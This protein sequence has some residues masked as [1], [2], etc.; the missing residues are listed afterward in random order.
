MLRTRRARPRD[1]RTAW[2]EC[3]DVDHRRARRQPHRAG[4][5]RHLHRDRDERYRR[6]A[7]SPPEPCC[8]STVV[9]CSASARS[10]ATP[11]H[12][13]TT[14]LVNPGKHDITAV[15]AGDAIYN[16]STSSVL[17][18]TVSGGAATTT[19]VVSSQNPST[20]GS[21]VTFTATVTV[22]NGTPTG[23]VAF[24]DGAATLGRLPLAGGAASIRDFRSRCGHARD[25]RRLRGR[26]C[27]PRQRVAPASC[28]PSLPSGRRSRARSSHRRASTPT[29]ARLRAPAAR[30]GRRW[31]RRTPAARSSSSTP[32][33]TDRR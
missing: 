2:S 28:E 12:S 33:A 22:G 25:H 11:R 31:R 32:P 6:P 3:R 24:K 18:E 19:G 30:S 14:A 16:G 10:R 13:T 9:R 26:R 4:R 21:V 17:V 1:C 20:L 23:T 15:Y 5:E 27:I 29:R 8:S 7:P